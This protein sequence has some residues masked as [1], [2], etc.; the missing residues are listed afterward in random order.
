MPRTDHYDA[1]T[2]DDDDIRP[3]LKKHRIRVAALLRGQTQAP[4]FRYPPGWEI[5]I[6]SDRGEVAGSQGGY[7]WQI[8]SSNRDL[9]VG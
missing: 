4:K 1:D 6:A 3:L 9:T 8:P 7:R 2:D 5:P